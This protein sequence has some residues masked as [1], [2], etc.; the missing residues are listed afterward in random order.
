MTIL[1]LPASTI[2]FATK[3]KKNCR[4][5]Y[6][7]GN[8]CI[9]KSKNCRKRLKGQ[10]KTYAG[11]LQK[12]A[13]GLEKEFEKEAGRILGKE[14][15]N[16]AKKLRAKSSK[17]DS[18]LS[19]KDR[20]D[21][22]FKED[23]LGGIDEVIIDSVD[24]L[25]KAN[26]SQI[27]ILKTRINQSKR[28]IKRYEG[29]LSDGLLDERN[30]KGFKD[31]IKKNKKEIVND[32]KEIKKLEA[33]IKAQKAE[34]ASKKPANNISKFSNVNEEQIDM[35]KELRSRLKQ[36]SRSERELREKLDDEIRSRKI[37]RQSALD[38]LPGRFE[39]ELKKRGK[40]PK[41]TLGKAK[42]IVIDSLKTDIDQAN[43]LIDIFKTQR[44]S[45]KNK[46]EQTSLDKQIK[47]QEKA[48]DKAESELRRKSKEWG[49]EP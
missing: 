30:T 15:T 48:R 31:L 41:K 32:E 10:A 34:L 26:E 47:D 44:K 42:K 1:K 49:I 2:D 27:K 40:K 36:A 23:G 29:L 12:Q 39:R 13:G 22:I 14:F 25:R 28:D 46:K 8:S 3:K 37:P 33:K 11:W 9:S 24:A 21:Q 6:P 17:N 38:D 18:D 5:S 7:C 4:K 45:T 20:V 35:M 43:S 16:E 19:L